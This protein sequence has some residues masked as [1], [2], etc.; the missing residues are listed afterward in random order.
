MWSWWFAILGATNEKLDYWSSF[1]KLL[2][3]SDIGSYLPNFSEFVLVYVGS[4]RDYRVN[5]HFKQQ[6]QLWSHDY[7]ARGKKYL[8]GY[9]NPTKIHHKNSGGSRILKEHSNLIWENGSYA[10][11]FSSEI[12]RSYALNQYSVMR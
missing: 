11:V 10:P 7:I 2:F 5:H 8:V 3:R 12:I 9:K 4:D 1:P 6:K